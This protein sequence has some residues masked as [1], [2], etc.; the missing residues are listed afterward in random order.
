LDVILKKEEKVMKKKVNLVLAGLVLAG[1]AV[2]LTV[3]GAEAFC[4]YNN[5]DREVVAA[6]TPSNFFR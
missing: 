4:V 1:L 3:E 6:Q 5:T 2:F